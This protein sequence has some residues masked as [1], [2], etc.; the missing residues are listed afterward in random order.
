MAVHCAFVCLNLCGARPLAE[1]FA[2]T[3][4]GGLTEIQMS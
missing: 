2:I 3:N 4:Y 1:Q